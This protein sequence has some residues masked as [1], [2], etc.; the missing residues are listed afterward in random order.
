MKGHSLRQVA[1]VLGF[2]AIKLKKVLLCILIGILALLPQGAM[3]GDTLARLLKHEAHA[4]RA[5]GELLLQELSCLACHQVSAP[6]QAHLTPKLGPL[7]G[8]Q[9]LPLTPQFIRQR[10]LEPNQEGQSR[11]MP[12]VLHAY[13]TDEKEAIVD[14]LTHYLISAQTPLDIEPVAADASTILR[15][16]NLYHSVGC[17]VCH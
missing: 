12:D 11:I 4:P 7:L 14:A 2:I 1:F 5:A 6:W 16:R 17:V 10:L 9:G 8:D 3:A 13:E 15:E